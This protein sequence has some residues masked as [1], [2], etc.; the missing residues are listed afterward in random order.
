VKKAGQTQDLWITVVGLIAA[1]ALLASVVVA[2]F[3]RMVFDDYELAADF[4]RL[5]WIG[6]FSSLYSHWS[7]RLPMN[8]LA[9]PIASLGVAGTAITGV[10]VVVWLWI[11]LSVVA[12]RA[13]DRAGWFVGWTTTVPLGAI[14]AAALL[15]GNASPFQTTRW[16]AGTT[17]YGLP[18][19]LALSALAI[20]LAP[21]RSKFREFVVV[22]S[23]AI[24]LFFSAG[25]NE[26]QALAQPALCLVIALTF[27]RHKKE[28]SVDSGSTSTD[29]GNWSRL[30][31]AVALVA[32]SAG[33]LVLLASPG[34]SERAARSTV[35]HAPGDVFSA[36]ITSIE[37]LFTSFL[38]FAMLSI[39]TL[40]A[41]GYLVRAALLKTSAESRESRE[42]VEVQPVN[43]SVDLSKPF[44]RLAL[45]AAVFGAVAVTSVSAYSLGAPAPLRAYLPTWTAL[46]VWI[47]MVGW[48]NAE[49]SAYRL[50]HPRGS[51]RPNLP[52]RQAMQW[53]V[54]AMCAAAPTM[55]TINR[56][57]AYP[58]EK[59][60][61]QEWA[62]IDHALRTSPTK[63]VSVAAVE[64]IDG[65]FFLLPEKG[66]RPNVVTSQFYGLR[67]ITASPQ[68]VCGL[69]R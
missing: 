33:G 25:G 20:S 66:K 50:A 67:S 34:S 58:K 18:A 28:S 16:V 2:T 1:V 23:L 6:S 15:F 42:S 69:K 31:L 36:L 10:V 53:A 60:R 13:L 11:A 68:G 65:I 27:W 63:D 41:L 46:A 12:K 35:S 14:S 29:P 61:A 5:G 56:M 47:T 37:V 55:L 8:L 39:A 51:K 17:V 43:R 9:G 24:C 26:T 7:G 54:V 45:L 49:R 3:T 64:Q 62:C 22:G 38:S 4:R 44:R 21:R 19:A 48:R 30:R 52:L 57:A 59:T 40:F 32:S